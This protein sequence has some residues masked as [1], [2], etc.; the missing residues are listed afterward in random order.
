MSSQADIPVTKSTTGSFRAARQTYGICFGGYVSMNEVATVER[1]FGSENILQLNAFPYV[2]IAL[3]IH[4][5]FQ[6]L[7]AKLPEL[8][9]ALGLESLYVIDMSDWSVR[10]FVIDK[11][12]AFSSEK[13]S[14]Q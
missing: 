10:E 6:I 8:C 5:A 9:N 14:G 4:N 12:Q 3:H 7:T 13:D 11:P 2:L 1:V